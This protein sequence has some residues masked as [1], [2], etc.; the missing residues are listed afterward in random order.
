MSPGYLIHISYEVLFKEFVL[1]DLF[2]GNDKVLKGV[3]TEFS[4]TIIVLVIEM[5]LLDS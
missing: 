1:S 3:S 2:S 4:I 5:L